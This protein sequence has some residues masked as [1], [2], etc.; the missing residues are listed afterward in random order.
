MR[1][2]AISTAVSLAA[3]LTGC[4]VAAE[5]SF[6]ART[7]AEALT[8]AVGRSDVTEASAA[9]AAGA[10]PDARDAD[11]RPLVLAATRSESTALVR[12]LL[13][14]GADPNAVDTIHDSA[15]LYAG[16]EGLTEILALTLEHGGDVTATNR[17]GGTAL[18]PAGEHA[19]VENVRLLIAAGTDVD[20]VNDLGWTALLEAIILGTGSPEHVETVRLL[21]DAGAD[22]TLAD[23][24]GVAP[25]THASRRGQD[26]IVALLDA[27]ISAR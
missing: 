7:S 16:A 8:H 15:F 17:F 3:L 11:G 10:D 21:L 14:A 22:P 18:I 20:H 23:A 5:P 1:T 12:V 9:L 19:H 27:A 24:D 6:T 4:S 26:E 2:A 25:R 13:E